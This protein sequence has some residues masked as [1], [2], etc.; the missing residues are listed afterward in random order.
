MS[1]RENEKIPE[2]DCRKRDWKAWVGEQEN[3]PEGQ[4]AKKGKTCDVGND[5]KLSEV[6]ETSRIWSQSYK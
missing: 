1:N 6:E 3:C 4:Q 5:A 2:E